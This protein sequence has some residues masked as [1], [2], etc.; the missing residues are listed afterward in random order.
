MIKRILVIVLIALASVVVIAQ[1]LSLRKIS[2]RESSYALNEQLKE[3][4][5][6]ECNTSNIDEIVEFSCNL[7]CELLS[8]RK[9]NSIDKGEANCVGYAK[10]T[11]AICN[12]AFKL[13]KL[14][15]KA[16]PVVGKVYWMN[17]DLNKLVGN[18]APNKWKS[19]IKDHDFVEIQTDSKTYYVD[20]S[21]KDL[22]GSDCKTVRK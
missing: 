20:S 18:I 5:R 6:K 11:A 17:S 15:A 10:L 19:F 8:F 21:L 4:V 9:R 16:T 2:N 3:R 1:T 12:Y 22:I 7:T 14:Q 13:N